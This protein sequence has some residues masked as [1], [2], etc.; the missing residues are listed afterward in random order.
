MFFFDGLHYSN[1]AAIGGFIPASQK[2]GRRPGQTS[3]GALSSRHFLQW[4]HQPLAFGRSGHKNEITLRRL[5]DRSSEVLV[6]RKECVGLQFP[7]HTAESLLYSVER[8]KK[9]ASVHLQTSA[10]EFPVC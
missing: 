3:G 9:G 10:A 8:M 4:R 5:S 6:Q 1:Y 2:M 7:K